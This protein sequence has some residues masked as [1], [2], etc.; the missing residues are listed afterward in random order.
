TYLA[1]IA[2]L[3]LSFWSLAVPPEWLTEHLYPESS[4]KVGDVVALFNEGNL[5]YQYARLQSVIWTGVQPE[6]LWEMVGG[7][8]VFQGLLSVACIAWAV[9]RLRAVAL[10]ESQS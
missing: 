9:L 5:G 2:Y 10:K 1:V 6:E 3:A 7:Y 8:A 4:W